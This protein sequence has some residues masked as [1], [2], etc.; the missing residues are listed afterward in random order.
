ML[1]TTSLYSAEHNGAL[2][3]CWFLGA[4][5]RQVIGTSGVIL[6]DLTQLES[7]QDLG[8]GVSH[9]WV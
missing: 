1:F 7:A 6:S 4:T 2:A 9:S 3:W 8:V 5:N